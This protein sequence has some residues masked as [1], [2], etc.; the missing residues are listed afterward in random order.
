MI[1]REV[2]LGTT[3]WPCPGT[4]SFDCLG[5]KTWQNYSKHAA[6]PFL[7]LINESPLMEWVNNASLRPM[8]KISLSCD[9]NSIVEALYTWKFVDIKN[10]KCLKLNL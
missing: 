2:S 1:R 3:E 7:L 9:I 10:D 5:Y 4:I 8:T 6:M